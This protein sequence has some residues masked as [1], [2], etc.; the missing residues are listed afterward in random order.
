MTTASLTE[1]G[2]LE[3]AAGA[4]TRAE[5]SRRFLTELA[6]TVYESRAL[7]NDFYDRWT[8]ERLSVDDIAILVRNYGQFNRAFPE[9]LAT[10]IMSTTNIA[11]RTEYAKT[12]FSEMGYGEFRAVHSNLFDAFFAELSAKFGTDKL[13]WETVERDVPLLPETIA[14]IEGEKRLY[15]TD[16][17][18][19][20]GAQ[21]A[22]E[23]QAYTMLRK[24]YDGACNY[25]GMWE[26]EDS[27]HEACEYYYTHIGAAEKEHKTESLNAA[28]EFDLDD[29][30][31]ARIV[32]GFHEHL[33]LFG[34]FWNALA[35]NFTS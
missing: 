11:A 19:G 33:D 9:V 3:G 34:N 23:W 10:M 16:E 2:S 5:D 32:A 31:R 26:T 30:S 18:T 6:L 29:A 35:R 14:L 13:T 22:L 7:N 12:L 21:L 17:A 20:S 8:R 24:L 28:I 4:I 27:F 25:K 1:F 15:R